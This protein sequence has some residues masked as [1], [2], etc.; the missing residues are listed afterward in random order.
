MHEFIC[1]L[2]NEGESLWPGV[3]MTKAIPTLL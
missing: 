3:T 1:I 2:M